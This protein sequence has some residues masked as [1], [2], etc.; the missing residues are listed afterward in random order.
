M[1]S[2]TKSEMFKKRVC[3]LLKY[4]IRGKFKINTQPGLTRYNW[5]AQTYNK[6]PYEESRFTHKTNA[7]E[8]IQ[9]IPAIEVDDDV[10]LCTG[11]ELGWGHPLQ[12]IT[13]NTRDQTKP[14][15]CKYCSLKY[16]KRSQH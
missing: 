7:E 10:V 11:G 3:V 13:L 8:L 9:D 1:N 6:Y 16:I 12:Y 14:S 2:I 15:V 5:D 4:Q